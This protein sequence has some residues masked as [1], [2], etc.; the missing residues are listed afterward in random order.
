LNQ[1]T[2]DRYSHSSESN[3]YTSVYSLSTILFMIQHN[4]SGTIGAC[5]SIIYVHAF[6]KI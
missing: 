6:W 1:L 4:Y 2:I 5:A 3:I